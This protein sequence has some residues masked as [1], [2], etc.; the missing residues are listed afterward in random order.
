MNDESPHIDR[1]DN[2]TVVVND[3]DAK[4]SQM[5]L[6]DVDNKPPPTFNAEDN[7]NFD[8]INKAAR[9]LPDSADPVTP[10]G[11]NLNKVTSVMSEADNSI[12]PVM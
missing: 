8:Q 11:K 10:T 7:D 9:E 6:L 1:T 3:D 2:S 4:R 12:N 5:T